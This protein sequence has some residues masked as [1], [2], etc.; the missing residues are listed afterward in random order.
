MKPQSEQTPGALPNGPARVVTDS[1]KD[2]LKLEYG[3]ASIF[4]GDVRLLR[5]G[6]EMTLRE[7]SARLF[8]VSKFDGWSTVTQTIR[9]AA[10]GSRREDVLILRGA[11]TGVGL[12]PIGGL[13]PETMAI[14]TPEITFI[15]PALYSVDGDWLL[16]SLP[17]PAIGPLETLAVPLNSSMED[18]EI[19]PVVRR[20]TL[21]AAGCDI[22][23]RFLPYYRAHHLQ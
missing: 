2:W 17:A 21:A 15:Q 8:V 14:V 4:Q 12:T 1:K 22:V 13:C 6:V 23:M 5:E 7:A 18:G 20:A 3:R 9:V 10:V 16:T 11:G 19:P